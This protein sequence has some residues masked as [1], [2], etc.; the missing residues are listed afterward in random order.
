MLKNN[1]NI[2]KS[3]VEDDVYIE[4]YLFSIN[5]KKY[6]EFEYDSIY[7]KNLIM[8]YVIEYM[9]VHKLMC[10]IVQCNNNI[11]K[12]KK[13][14][15]KQKKIYFLLHKKLSKNKTVLLYC[16]YYD[17]IPARYKNKYG[18]Y[19]TVIYSGLLLNV[20]NKTILSNLQILEDIQN[21][22]N[23]NAESI[24]NLVYTIKYKN[25]YLY[26]IKKL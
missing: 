10:E 7:K 3:I 9:L 26:K 8:D 16:C 24:G 13:L 5:N 14:T 22:Y 20:L 17:I 1:K 19:D 23:R 4:M 25:I 2:I 6:L 18:I 15:K 21:N 12:I 11:I